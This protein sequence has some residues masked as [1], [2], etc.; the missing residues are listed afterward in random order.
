MRRSNQWWLFCLALLVGVTLAA[1]ST[2]R[3]A[4]P[5][6]P[7]LSPVTAVVPETGVVHDLGERNSQV[8]AV[9]PGDVIAIPL[10]GE[11]ASGLQWSFR[12][13]INGGALTLKRHTVTDR[14]P[15]LKSR[16]ILSE[17]VFKVEKAATF[18]LRFDYENPSRRNRPVSQT[19]A[20]KI[21]ADRKLAELPDLVLDE[22]VANAVAAGT[23]R[24]AGY[25][26]P[27]IEAV[28]YSLAD[29]AGKSVT[30]GAIALPSSKGEFAAFEKTIKFRA[31][32]SPSGGITVQGKNLAFKAPPVPLVFDPQR[33]TVQAYFGNKR[34]AL[35]DTCRE[36]FPVKRYV[37][38]TEGVAK[39]ALMELLAGPTAADRSAGYG[40]SL[41]SGV[42]L[43]SITVA[44]GVAIADFSPKLERGVGGSCRVAAIRAQIERTLKQ[45]P[46]VEDVVISI[47]GRT[48]DILQ[49]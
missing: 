15:R 26:R 47:D 16:Q 27:R 34:Q 18:T 32:S 37:P 45:F 6:A 41:P 12:S 38:K 4:A 1:C 36:V 35:A 30:S 2:R 46:T 20:V 44:G 28:E 29:D 23:V 22:P 25:A 42:K 14:D 31:P 40:T 7:P 11:A 8:I 13:P 9:T 17:W 5:P 3:T 19:F 21:V 33:V 43:N 10:V 49:P 24:V 48:E 39:A